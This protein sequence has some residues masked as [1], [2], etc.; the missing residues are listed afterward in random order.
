MYASAEPVTNFRMIGF[1]AW[2]MRT[3]KTIGRLLLGTSACLLAV[4]AAVYGIQGEWP[5]VA[6]TALT[7]GEAPARLERAVPGLAAVAAAVR[8]AELGPV[9][10]LLGAALLVFARVGRMWGEWWRTDDPTRNL[11]GAKDG[12]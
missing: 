11:T 4:Q 3:V 10:G 8:A 6:L 5:T 1:G 9:A 12:P 7:G 2:T